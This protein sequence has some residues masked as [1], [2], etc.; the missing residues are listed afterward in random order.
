MAEADK[1]LTMGNEEKEKEAQVALVDMAKSGEGVPVEGKKE[2]KGPQPE[3]DRASEEDEATE[4]S[5]LCF[6][7]IFV[8][9]WT[10]LSYRR[11]TVGAP[12]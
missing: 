10:V 8:N 4:G 5:Y 11:C 12:K 9:I 2:E 3:G 7:R 1:L 6:C